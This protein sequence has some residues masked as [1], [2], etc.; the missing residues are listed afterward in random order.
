MNMMSREEVMKSILK[1]HNHSWFEDVY[2]RNKDRSNCIALTYRGS[3]YT[4]GDFF[5][6]VKAYTK[7][8]K[9][10]GIE[11]GTEFVACLEQT[12]DY[13]VLVAAASYIGA[14]IN[15]VNANFDSDY[16]ASIIS[17]ADAKIVLVADWDLAKLN[18]ALK[19][20]CQDKTIVSLPVGKWDKYNNP[21]KEITD[22]FFKF[23]E[24]EYENCAKEFP[25]LITTDEFLEHGVDYKGELCG[26]TTLEDPL[27]ITY[28]SGSTSKGIH[29]GVVQKNGSYI[30]MG[31]YHDHEVAGI[32]KMDKTITLACA[33]PHA[34]TVLMSG[35]SDT[36]IQGGI[37][38][39][40]PII[41]ERYFLYALKFS[42]AGLAIA[43]RTFW[44]RA[45]KETY[46]NPEFKD[47]KLPGLYVPSEGGEPLS[48][49]EEKAL[50]RWLRDIDA[51]V[52][53][54][55]TPF[56]IVKM[57]VG[58]GDSE[59][60]SLFLALFR[61]Y[62]NQLQK[63]RGIKEPIGLTAYDFVDIVALR[64]DGTHCA[65][66]ELGRL[67]ANS[68]ISMKEYHNNPEATA[69]YYRK[70]A[71]G[72]SWGDLSNY[73]YLDKWKKVYLKGRIGK[74]DPKV[75][76]FQIADVIALDTKNIM[77]CEVIFL[78]DG[79]EDELPTYIAHIETQYHKKVNVEKAL[80]SAQKRCEAKFGD[81]IKGKLLFRVRSHEEGFPTLFTA[82]RNLIA[83]KEEGITEKCVVPSEVYGKKE[84]TRKLTKRRY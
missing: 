20:S 17:K 78:D 50:N 45:M 2:M 27:A 37:L 59:H 47:L 79:T 40:D 10:Y 64:E 39:L 6:M 44:L 67:V 29:K 28:T 54:T 65:P 4:Y 15:L 38:A 1:D 52:A 72:T 21:Y 30:I 16:M 23:D 34:D 61:A 14:K 31:R 19:K 22:R 83:L 84:E 62:Y 35:V 77:S 11:K 66:M 24:E 43:T 55:H 68:P 81:Q 56:S 76:P 70:D 26:H 57:T 58:G 13:P 18:P 49:G 7:A 63:I 74:K 53:I 42:N 51:G 48:G 80:L 8:L 46:E 3:K 41:D 69:A 12:P 60:G 33:G 73:G 36:L 9:S 75:L 25:N 5:N 82:K 71:Y 32:P